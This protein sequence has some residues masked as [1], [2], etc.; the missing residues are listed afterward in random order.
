MHIKEICLEGFK[1]YATRTVVPGFDPYFNAI[2]GLNGLGKSNIL[3]SICFV[4]GITNSQQVRASNL[5][6][7]VYK[8]GQAGIT[9]S[10]VSVVFDNSDRSRS[11]L[12]YDDSIEIT[13]TRQACFALE[14]GGEIV[15]AS[16]VPKPVEIFIRPPLPVGSAGGKQFEFRELTE[17]EQEVRPKWPICD[18]DISGLGWISVEPFTQSSK[19]SES[20]AVE[21][22]GEIVLVVHVPKPVEIFIRPPLSVGSAGGKQFEFRELT[23][24]EQEVR[25]KWHGKYMFE[26]E[27]DAMGRADLIILSHKRAFE[28]LDYLNRLFLNLPIQDCQV[29]GYIISMAC[30]NPV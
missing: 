14:C 15:L 9:K 22:G 5:Q 6:E 27:M 17:E 18:V 11:P 28:W 19:S 2:I 25:P 4:L 8:Q 7:L 29:D 10:T 1:S 13:V 26:C 12:G 3:G 30:G 23:E 20:S 16:H 21:C 24:E